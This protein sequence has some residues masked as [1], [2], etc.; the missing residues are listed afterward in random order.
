M[1]EITINEPNLTSRGRLLP[2]I[3]LVLQYATIQLTRS[4]IAKPLLTSVKK[5]AFELPAR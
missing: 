2:A 1:S 4:P 3:S 5:V